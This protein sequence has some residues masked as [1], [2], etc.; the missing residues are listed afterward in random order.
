MSLLHLQKSHLTIAANNF[1]DFVGSARRTSSIFICVALIIIAPFLVGVTIQGDDWFLYLDSGDDH[2]KWLV[3]IGRPLHLVG[4]KVFGDGQHAHPFPLVL[5]VLMLM[6]V[7]ISIT[8]KLKTDKHAATIGFAIFLS[9]PFWVEIY[10]FSIAHPAIAI[11]CPFILIAII[12]FFSEKNI[13]VTRSVSVGLFLGLASLAKQDFFLMGLSIIILIEAFDLIKCN[14]FKL[15]QI[16]NKVIN[17]FIIGIT[18]LLVYFLIVKITQHIFN[19]EPLANGQYSLSL[20][21]NV[22]DGSVRM[23][24]YAIVYFFQA[25]AHYPIAAKLLTLLIFSVGIISLLLQRRFLGAFIFTLTIVFLYT[26]AMSLGLIK[27]TAP[28]RYNA[29][30]ALSLIPMF[31]FLTTYSIAKS[32]Q[33]K[34]TTAFLGFAVAFLNTAE[35]NMAGADARRMTQRD[36]MFINNLLA[37]VQILDHPSRKIVLYGKCNGNPNYVRH[38]NRPGRNLIVETPAPWDSTIIDFGSIDCQ[39]FR[40]NNAY[41]LM[42]PFQ[43]PPSRAFMPGPFVSYENLSDDQKETVKQHAVSLNGKS[44]LQQVSEDLFVYHLGRMP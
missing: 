19:I 30:V 1:R 21:F 9:S 42:M 14:K 41:H 27:G 36:L 17:I 4:L 32:R 29:V 33:A 38:L 8:T 6:F 18:A 2:F 34:L 23:I 13:S 26:I 5:A 10:Q 22:I 16:F 39:K 15:R 28:Y 35:I 31:I 12:L 44:S 40:A 11:S 20:E 43:N 37:S 25:Q 7:Y 3:R 24:E